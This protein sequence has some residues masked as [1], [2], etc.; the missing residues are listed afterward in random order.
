MDGEESEVRVPS[1]DRSGLRIGLLSRGA[2]PPGRQSAQA[3]ERL[4]PLYEV[5]GRLGVVV[6]PVVYAED[7]VAEVRAQILELDGV[8]VWVNPVQDGVDRSRLD[9][10]LLEA[11]D[12]GVWVSA[13][14][15][16]IARM[17]TKEVLYTTR[18]LGWGSA[19]EI[20]RSEQELA[21]R[22]PARIAKHGVLVLKQGRGTGGAGVW[23]VELVGPSCQ[24]SQEPGPDALVRVQHAKT[25]DPT[26]EEMPLTRFLERCRGYF[27]GSGVMVDQ[28]FQQRLAEGMI[29][30]YFV[31]DQ[32][33]GFQHQWPEA[34]LPGA[35]ADTGAGAG[36]GGAVDRPPTTRPPRMH[37]MEPPETPAYRGLRQSLEAEWIPQMARLLDLDAAALPVIWDADFLYGPTTVT[38]DD[39]FVLCE[40]NAS[41]VW[42]FPPSAASTIAEAA[43][44]RVA[45][46]TAAGSAPDRPLVTDW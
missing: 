2:R 29:R 4:A 13:H 21:E 45:Q 3:V 39:T 23:R 9:A 16:V 32:L 17:G 37:V 10:L 26:A 35:G 24:S 15:D 34:L 30:A 6:E 7:A 28:P 20:Y 36:A 46:A 18:H 1:G 31:H 8:L 41:C 43:L 42:P 25:R 19:T 38:G 22:F 5:L 12:R 44:D 27:S 40:I 14:P 11:A 33:V